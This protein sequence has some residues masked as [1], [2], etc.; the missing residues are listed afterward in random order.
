MKILIRCFLFTLIL[1][2]YIYPKPN[3]FKDIVKVI[4]GKDKGS[5]QELLALAENIIKKASYDE[6]TEKFHKYLSNSIERF[7]F[8][9]LYESEY[10][11]DKGSGFRGVSYKGKN[12]NSGYHIGII[13]GNI[14][15]V[16]L[17][18]KGDFVA[19]FLL[20]RNKKVSTKSKSYSNSESYTGKIS[21]K[22][23]SGKASHRQALL[24]A[25][26][27][28]TVLSSSNI[29]ELLYPKVRRLFSN[30]KD[31]NSIRILGDFENSYSNLS[32][33]LNQY[34]SLKSLLFTGP[35]K[36]TGINIKGNLR[37]P[38]IRRDFPYMGDYLD[39]LESLG[40]VHIT[41]Y[42]QQRH[43]L[44]SFSLFSENLEF[45]CRLY[46]L[47]GKVIPFSKTKLY[48]AEAFLPTQL[49]Q[50]VFQI[51]ISFQINVY[52]LYFKNNKVL[53]N[54]NFSDKSENG[55]L[56]FK[57]Q[58]I[59]P[60]QV[61]GG[62]SHI[63]PAWLIDMFIPGNIEELI[64]HFTETMVRANSGTG[65][66]VHLGFTKKDS[67]LFRIQAESEFLNNFLVRFGLKV[68]NYRILPYEEARD[69]IR[70]FLQTGIHFL[71]K[72]LR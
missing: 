29:S 5:S 46:T 70:K 61:S 51:H 22:M 50:Y 2:S 33:F 43:K 4:E 66:F 7:E 31:E 48:L 24:L 45:N 28:L 37:L 62:F 20:R 57:L 19:E 52:G 72:D 58:N 71:M 9:D 17:D 53:V 21:S 49:K 67:F 12:K 34:V 56:S 14:E 3:H 59:A 23:N 1:S 40:S 64:Q 26:A 42:N 41:L 15:T 8:K 69:D 54:A 30:L 6:H 13:Q 18:S 63:V 27:L 10:L 16:S 25:E 68:W 60:T 11:S 44:L 32:S 55:K 65:S 39:D 35:E 47:E 36:S 38:F